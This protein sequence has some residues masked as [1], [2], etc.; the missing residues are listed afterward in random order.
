MLYVLLDY[1]YLN[2]PRNFQKLCNSEGNSAVLTYIFPGYRIIFAVVVAL[3]NICLQ[4]FKLKFEVFGPL[5]WQCSYITKVFQWFLSFLE[6]NK[7]ILRLWKKHFFIICYMYIHYRIWV[8]KLNQTCYRIWTFQL[9]AFCEGN[10]F[11]GLFLNFF[12][13]LEVH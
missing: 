12:N 3:F 9:N 6:F 1:L 7:F 13:H 5:V 8:F 11:M 4:F 10:L 2:D